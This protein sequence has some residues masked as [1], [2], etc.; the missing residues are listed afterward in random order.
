MTADG[1]GDEKI[2]P[3]GLPSYSI[4]LPLPLVGPESPLDLLTPDLSVTS[5]EHEGNDEDAQYDTE[6][7]VGENERIDNVKYHIYDH[8]IIN[9]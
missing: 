4:P 5:E 1:S 7:D 8:T 3:E 2:E 6:K 9:R